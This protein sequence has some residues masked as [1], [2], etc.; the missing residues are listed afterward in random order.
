[1]SYGET[2][3]RKMYEMAK[4]RYAEYGVDVDAALERAL[5]IPVSMH[6][7]QTDDVV[8]FETKE[9]G[10]DGG[11]IMATG[12]Y[13]GRARN[14]DESRA[15]LEQAMALIPGKARV[16]IHAIY[17]ETGGR[18]VDRDALEPEH[19]S[20][21]MDWARAQGVGLDFNPTFFG[22]PKADDGLSLSHPDPA[23]RRFWVDHGHACRKI[24]KAMAES[25]GGPCCVNWWIPDGTKDYAADRWSPRERLIESY[26]ALFK[27][28]DDSAGCLD[29]V[30][31]KLFGIGS[32]A[33]VAGSAEFYSNYALSRGVGLCLDM[34][35]FHPTEE[36]YDKI[37]SQLLFQQN[38]LLHVSRPMRWD[39]D[40]VVLFSDDLQ[41]VFQE[42]QR[43]SAWDRVFVAED[44][45]DASI[46]RIAAYVIGTRAVR[47]AILMA[48]LEPVDQLK[49]FEN[50]GRCAERLGLM[51]EEKT[52]PFAAVWDMLCARA[53]VPVGGA[54][55]ERVREYEQEVLKTRG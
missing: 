50:E 20:A 2:E 31:S 8:G 13:P 32:E 33:Y 15:D 30:E 24:G 55:M 26:D 39:S 5:E 37:S 27:A 29:F 54:W 22:H 34:G 18:V 45:F 17:A 10:L 43:G 35:H 6:C 7:W 46:N 25:Q 12:G 21:W 44:F 11:G 49:A 14:G 42:V 51:E 3:I 19:F 48:L 23:I 36:I 40:H 38:L 16:N 1:M 28:G 47:K 52:L 53:G 41:R 4:E 9:E